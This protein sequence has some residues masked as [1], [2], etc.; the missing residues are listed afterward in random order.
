MD[1]FGL[2]DLNEQK[3][4]ALFYLLVLFGVLEMNDGL[5]RT[6]KRSS[7]KTAKLEN[8]VGMHFLDL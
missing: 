3:V 8:V 6:S 1:V 5:D 4:E 2:W 7:Y